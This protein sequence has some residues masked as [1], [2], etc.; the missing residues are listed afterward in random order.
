MKVINQGNTYRIFEDDISITSMLRPQTYIIRFNN[1]QGFYLENHID[2]VINESKIYG[3][4]DTKV[5]KVIKAFKVSK[6]NLG[7]LLSGT[8]GSGKSLFAK[9]LS[10]ASI[11]NEIPVIVVDQYIPGIASFIE[12]IK[13]EAMIL[14]DEFEKTFDD[15]REDGSQQTELLTLLDGITAGKK[16]FVATCND[17]YALNDCFLNRPGRFHYH[18]RFDSPGEAEIR[19]YLIDAIGNTRPDEIEKVV[20]FGD[21]VDLTYDCLRALAFELNQGISFEE[22][23]QCLN[24]VCMGEDRYDVTAHFEGGDILVESDVRLTFNENHKTSVRFY[25]GSRGAFDVEFQTKDIIRNGKELIVNAKN[26]SISFR[27]TEFDK[28]LL[29][30]SIKKS[31][32]RSIKYNITI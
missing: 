16:L 29:Y 21:L 6:R 18:Y 15:K 11:K 4:L 19:E 32:L 12:S 23:M 30:L 24:I 28:E 5:D 3:S 13:Q 20:A 7:V 14:L 27:T 17:M 25:K 8:K 1:R 9:M 2:I 22:S 31:P 26:T 10:I